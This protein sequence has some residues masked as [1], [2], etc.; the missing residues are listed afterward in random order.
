MIK[1]FAIIVAADEKMGI[2]RDNGLPWPRL[3]G[4][5]K[6]FSDITSGAE[7][8]KVN[9]VIMGRKTWESLPAKHRP[10]PGRLNVV[11]SR[12]GFELVTGVENVKLSQDGYEGD[13]ARLASSL[14]EALEMVSDIERIDKVFVIGGANVFEQAL[15]HENCKGVF[16]TEVMDKFECDTFLAKIPAKFERAWE[17]EVREDNGVKYRFVVLGVD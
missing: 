8:G 13:G 15:K 12:S 17:S 1:D 14:E 5:M 2:G 3:K 9:A 7:D 10:L 16:L 4:D 11:M 6:Y